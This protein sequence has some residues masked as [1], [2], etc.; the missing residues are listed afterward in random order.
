MVHHESDPSAAA[1]VLR[2]FLFTDLADST[3]WKKT[4]G[5]R[6][7]ALQVLKP[8]DRLFRTLLGDYPGA[9]VNNDMGDGYLATFPAPGGAVQFALRFHAALTAEPWGHAVRRSG[10]LPATRVGIHLGEHVELAQSGTPKLAGQAVDLAARVMGL[11]RPGQTLLTR[12]AFDSARQYVRVNPT[13]PA[14]PLT[15][16]AHG[17]YRFKGNDDDPLEVFGV[18]PEGAPELAPPP[19][20]EKARRVRVDDADD[21]GAWRPG[22][23]LVIPG[24]EG[25]R[26]ERPLGEGGFGEVW[27]ACQPRTK[28]QRVFKFCFAAE[29]LRSFK[30]ELTLFRLLKSEFGER[31]DFVRLNDVQFDRPPYFI[32]SEYVAGGNLCDWVTARGFDSW[33]VD[34]RV[35]FVAAVARTVAAAHQLGIIH[36]DLKPA[37]LLVREV[38][39]RPHPVVAD[40]GIGVLT[41]RSILNQRHIT[42]TGGT[43]ALAGNESNRTGTRLY[44]PPE[45]LVGKP[46]TTGYDV[47]AL[48]VVLYQTL[49]GDF[50]QPLGTGWEENL[51]GL[52][53]A[54]L[55]A[56]DIRT[57]TLPAD[58]RLATVTVLADRL[59]SLSERERLRGLERRAASQ[60]RRVLVLRR[61]LVGSAV[62]LLMVGGL[63]AYA[64]QQAETARARTKDAEDAV[65]REKAAAERAAG[66]A[67]RADRE[68]G[69]AVRARG[70]LQL[71]LS[72]ALL[73]PMQAG[74]RNA[75]PTP[76]EQEAFCGLASLRGSAACTFFLEEITRTPHACRQLE[77]RAEFVWHALV[78]L[79]PRCREDVIRRFAVMRD[80]D[81]P[82]EQRRSLA[83]ACSRWDATPPDTAAV[84]ARVL[85]D[86][87]KREADPAR[88]IELAAGLIVLCRRMADADATDVGTQAAELISGAASK[89]RVRETRIALV[90]C[91]AG[92]SSRIPSDDAAHVLANLASHPSDP[93]SLGALAL[94]VS[95]AAVR[96]SPDQAANTCRPVAAVV[97][98]AVSMQ[99]RPEFLWEL[100]DGLGALV[101]HLPAAEGAALCTEGITRAQSRYA[102]RVLAECLA[103]V[104]DLM[105]RA[106]AEQVC[107]PAATHLADRVAPRVTPVAAERYEAAL[108]VAAL[109]RH[110]DKTKAN[111]LC[112]RVLT[113]LQ[114]APVIETTLRRLD[115]RTGDDV[116]ATL[117]GF[118]DKTS[119]VKGRDRLTVSSGTPI[120]PGNWLSTGRLAQRNFYRN[121]VERHVTASA[122]NTLAL[123]WLAGDLSRLMSARTPP[124]YTYRPFLLALGS[125][126]APPTLPA[127]ILTCRLSD[128]VF[129][130]PPQE[131]VELL[132]HPF[133]VGEAQRAVLD[134]MEFT[135]QRRFRD[136]WDFVDYARAHQPQLDLLTPPP[137]LQP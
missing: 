112:L 68:K 108:G 9:A 13:D 96:Q 59:E 85:L 27:L 5:D 21:T 4:L 6:D 87:L 12:H 126:T 75:A 76:Y 81:C 57:A 55:L 123:G 64:W 14:R 22:V 136:L 52:P 92:V 78:G 20:S 98:E 125:F 86:E 51:R 104:A 25:W 43:Q 95:A 70:D 17:Q 41:D 103:G 36:K 24:R 77:C 131:L 109:A 127:P 54:D 137:R 116:E 39:G 71:A 30:R 38:N 89:A 61:A 130:L 93:D 117:S 28:D 128:G 134:A 53:H 2:V 69:E 74:Q 60:A 18:G 66:E 91:L 37:N 133:C 7:Y 49:V 65:A 132:K 26:L 67:A 50:G 83:L 135:H 97:A 101:G 58:R 32:E 79:D 114:N 16:V 62:V 73:G 48:G 106:T 63:G 105:E 118:V 113:T 102:A 23:G 120:K 90:V 99:R 100:G 29:R 107:L 40:F 115:D 11:A 15:F 46:A 88:Q 129:W 84:A 33:P 8:H 82:P 3:A 19:D 80:T 44:A 72:R 111:E 45:A 47:Y 56:D 122:V 110:L 34:D 124:H 94:A 119:A 1:S 31:P 42:A 121:K 10:R 35:R